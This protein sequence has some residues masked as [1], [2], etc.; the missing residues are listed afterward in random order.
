PL[1]EVPVDRDDI[2]NGFPGVP[3]PHWDSLDAN[4]REDLARRGATFAAM[5]EHVDRGVGRLL[6]D[7]KQNGE[8]ENTLIL[9]TSDNGA[10]YEWGPFGFDGP[11]RKGLTILHKGGDLRKIGQDGTHQSYGSGWANLGNTPLNMYKHFCHEG[12]IA[13]P[14]IAHWPQ[15]IARKD[16]WVRDPSHIMDIVPTVL[17]ATGT[18]YPAS[19][20]GREIT[21]VEGTSLLA[22]FGGKPLAERALA[23]EHQQ[24]RGLRKGDWKIVW[25][26]RQPHEV[27]WELYNLREDRSEQIDLARTQPTRTAGLVAEWEAW[28]KRV[29]AEP[30]HQDGPTSEAATPFPGHPTINIKNRPLVI[31]CDVEP[32]GKDGVIVSQG[33]RE[34][35]YALHLVNGHLAF[36]LRVHGKVTRVESKKRLPGRFKASASFDADRISLEANGESLAA[37]KSPG[38]IPV[39]PKDGLDVGFDGQ[40][41][42]GD[43]APPNRFTGTIHAIEVTAPRKQGF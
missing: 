26:K 32:A 29:G 16:V 27:R 39:Q 35:G 41:A 20:D 43:Y 4:R 19:R 31:T 28:A 13:S 40:S 42:A 15:G 21:P 8:L 33:G 6:A 22:A 38:L 34:H 14:L 11:S 18:P 1:S 3:N 30:F 23:F 7:L 25:G 9:F 37:A 2:A 24:A 17:E 10:C 36:D 12:G 5:V